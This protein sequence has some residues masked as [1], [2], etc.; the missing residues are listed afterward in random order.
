[1]CKARAIFN[2]MPNRTP[3]SWTILMSGYAH[4]GP[5]IEVLALL[6]DMLRELSDVGGLGPDPFVLSVALKACASVGSL[7]HG[8]E[9]HCA[10]VKLG[11]LEDLF[12]ANGLVTMYSS[13][14]SV[15][16]SR[17]VFERI[18]QPDLV[19]WTSLLSG[20]VRNGYE[21]EA[22]R[23]FTGMAQEE[24]TI[25]FDAY[26]LS[27]CLK[28]SC[29][30]NHTGL[31]SMIHCHMIKMGFASCLFL[32]NSLLE[33]YGRIG[34]LGLMRKVLGKMLEKDLVSLNTVISCHARSNHNE[35]ALM[36]F[37]KLMT[38]RGSPSRCDDF[39]LG[40]VLQAVSSS[41]ALNHGKEI[42]GYVI[43]ASFGSNSYV[44][45][46][47]LDMYVT[48]VGLDTVPVRLFVHFRSLGGEVDEFL[49]AGIVKWCASVKDPETGK[50]IH[51]CIVKLGLHSDSFVASSLIDMYAKCGILGSSVRVFA[52]IQNPGTVPW[53]SIIA[54][55]CCSGEFLEALALFREMQS[56]RV[57]ANEFTYSSALLACLALGDHT[58][59]GTEIH[60]S[61]IRRGYCLNAPVVNS[62]IS[63]YSVRGQPHKA[64]KLASLLGEEEIDWCSLIRAFGR[65]EDRAMILKLFHKIQRSTRGQV[66]HELAC[67]VIG[68]CGCPSL[69]DAG[70]QVHA[71]FTKRGL[72]SDPSTN[73]SLIGMYSK[74]GELELA[75]DA[76]NRMSEKNS[77][78]WTAIVAAYV[79]EGRPSEALNQFGKM[80]RKGKRPDAETFLY[81]L[82]ACGEVGLIEEAFRLF[83]C[84]VEVYKLEPSQEIY[85][86]MVEAMGSAGMLEE[87]EHFIASVIPIEADASSFNLENTTSHSIPSS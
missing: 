29:N 15:G 52:G 50:T 83:T 70:V 6:R 9:V 3:V 49:V 78:S 63:L 41:G 33:F 26:V 60:C 81:A 14:G 47:L 55:H 40:S 30:S 5:C 23:L 19:S 46:A 10:A 48:C 57:R 51:A 45:S 66:D 69:L 85:S 32:M 31:G 16:Y 67:Y 12:V 76:F 56:D 22:L 68:S 53:S 1:M 86:S 17:S 36:F 34:E 13:C 37:R 72:L 8:H 77:A 80:V 79:R 75:V 84:M 24:A 61:V 82:K 74:C 27:I 39:T 43:R 2:A 11:Y 73:N 18:P 7:K 42:H 65:A 38:S 71:Y 25:R 21:E 62:L 58:S 28:A 4:H 35:D 54:A 59:G 44:T 87:A 20:L 64:M